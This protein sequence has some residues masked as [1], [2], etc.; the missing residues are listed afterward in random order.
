MVNGTLI[1]PYNGRKLWLVDIPFSQEQNCLQV[2]VRLQCHVR[3]I[4]SKKVLCGSSKRAFYK[5]SVVFKGGRGC[6]SLL[7]NDISIELKNMELWS[8]LQVSRMS[9]DVCDSCKGKNMM[10]WY[11]PQELSLMKYWNHN[12]EI[13]GKTKFRNHSCSSKL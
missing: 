5:S 8:S 3:Y 2:L 13:K 1:Q 12:E 11:L 6:L 7:Y 9:R 10:A 4:S